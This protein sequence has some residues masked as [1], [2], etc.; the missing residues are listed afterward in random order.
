MNPDEHKYLAPR[1]GERL[2]KF[3]Y[4]DSLVDDILGDLDEIYHDRAELIGA[5]QAKLLY[6]KDA[7]LSFRNYDLRRKRKVTQN[8]SIPMVGNYVK[9]TFRTLSKNRIYSALNIMGLALGLAACLFFVQYVDYEYSYDKFHSNHENIYRVKYM[10]Y[11]SGEL[12]IDCAAA[13]PRVGPFMKEKMPEVFD[14]VRA[15]PM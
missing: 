11:R 4:D 12:D 10:V 14:F 8:N 1:L 15:F 5:R 6:L 7:V 3:I 13:V 2:L 9:T